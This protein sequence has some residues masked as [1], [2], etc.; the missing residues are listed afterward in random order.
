MTA[1]LRILSNS[2]FTRHPAA[3]RYTFRV[4]SD[5]VKLIKILSSCSRTNFTTRPL[6]TVSDQCLRPCP[7]ILKDLL[8]TARNFLRFAD[9][10]G[11][12]SIPTPCLV[13]SRSAAARL[14]DSLYRSRCGHGHS[15]LV[16]A[17]C[18]AGSCPCDGLIA[19]S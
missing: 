18:C 2:L 19:R 6:F 16:F 11:I 12:P 7:Y 17:V 4:N 1:T 8:F 9:S 3:R 15:S 14:L 10:K 5:V 13:M